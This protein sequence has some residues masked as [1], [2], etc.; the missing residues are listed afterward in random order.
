MV[1]PLVYDLVL[2]ILDNENVIETILII[3]II[4]TGPPLYPYSCKAS[5]RRK[6]RGDSCNFYEVYMKLAPSQQM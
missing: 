1:K 2:C 6:Q 4:K 3:T 5:C